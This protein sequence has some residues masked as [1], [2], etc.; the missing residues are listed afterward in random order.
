[1]NATDE[2]VLR[3]SAFTD[4][5]EGGNPAG[6]VLDAHHLSDEQMLA[7]AGEVGYSETA[8][9]SPDPQP[10][11]ATT[12]SPPRP[13]RGWRNSTT[14]TR[15]SRPTCWSATSRRSISSGGPIR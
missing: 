3:Y 9:L 5:G 12:S 13:A 8:F 11:P 1:M 10:V 6:V 7:I 2:L 15:A 14:T 4:N